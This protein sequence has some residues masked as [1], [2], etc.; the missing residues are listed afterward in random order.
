MKKALLYIGLLV[1]ALK[2]GAQSVPTGLSADVSAD[3]QAILI[4]EPI[5]LTLTVR[6]TPGHPV[7]V[8]I[9]DSLPHFEVLTRSKIDTVADK[10]LLQLQQVVTLT[11][12]DSGHWEIPAF[13][14]A[15][16]DIVTDSLGVDVGF[17]PMKPND[18]LR[19]I[20]D[21]VPVKFSIPWWIIGVS[22]IVL[23]VLIVLLVRTLRSRHEITTGKRAA[24]LD[25][26]FEEA[27]KALEDLALPVATADVKPY[28]TRLDAILKRF[29]SRNFGWKTSQFT[30]T[31]LLTHL[32]DTVTDPGER[33]AIAETLRLEDAVKFAR[34]YPGNDLHQQ[35]K[36]RVR[37][38]LDILHKTTPVS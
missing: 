12:F 9:P 23:A 24:P 18:Q 7:F 17:I 33:S 11:S 30:T 31:D 20:K 3:R 38:A 22:A 37:K 28:Y 32:Q 29:L 14:L 6:S 21:I 13:E 2:A 19:D 26:P 4:G 27:V 35:A 16:T 1:L 34:F 25:P 15:G 10:D 36:E 5:R 8:T